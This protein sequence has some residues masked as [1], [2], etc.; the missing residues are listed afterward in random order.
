LGRRR[1]IPPVEDPIG[2]TPAHPAG[3]IFPR[4]QHAAPGVLP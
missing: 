1:R 3:L 4:P 2:A